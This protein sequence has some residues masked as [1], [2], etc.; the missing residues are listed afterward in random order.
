M[1]DPID[2]PDNLAKTQLPDKLKPV[3]RT[4]PERERNGFS[5]ALQEEL[6]E[7]LKKKRRKQGDSVL[8]EHK[9]EEMKQDN[10]KHQEPSEDQH[11]DVEETATDGES[12]SPENPEPAEESS[13]HVDLKA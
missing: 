10:D 9:T 3:V 7:E 4:N 5:K 1:V 11:E 2:V 13:R 6:E 12:A 8:I